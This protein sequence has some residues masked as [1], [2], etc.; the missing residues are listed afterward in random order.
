[1]ALEEVDCWLPHPQPLHARMHARTHP[2]TLSGFSDFCLSVLLYCSHL[3]QLAAVSSVPN[4]SHGEMRLSGAFSLIPKPRD[5]CLVVGQCPSQFQ[6]WFPS[7]PIL[8]S[9]VLRLTSCLVASLQ[10]L[11]A[12][13]NSVHILWLLVVC[14]HPLKF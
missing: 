4:I 14:P 1:M 9:T 2:C 11:W 12:D 8:G 3:S 10:F 13:D 6:L 5:G 7:W